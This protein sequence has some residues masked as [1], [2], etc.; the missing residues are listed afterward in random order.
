MFQVLIPYL[1]IVFK[2]R[3]F[4]NLKAEKS[5]ISCPFSFNRSS[6]N[7]LHSTVFYHEH[8]R[9]SEIGT[10][11]GLEYFLL[12]LSLRFSSLGPLTTYSRL[13]RLISPFD[14]PHVRDHLYRRIYLFQLNFT[15]SRNYCFFYYNLYERIINDVRR[16]IY[17][18]FCY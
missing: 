12:R 2:I 9:H 4:I 17:R 14:F 1:E 16:R 10:A 8:F 7:L 3:D 18:N 11:V 6:H 13:S 5:S 15:F